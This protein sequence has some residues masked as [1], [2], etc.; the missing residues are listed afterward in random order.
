MMHGN[1]K[2]KLSVLVYFIK[3]YNFLQK[4]NKLKTQA[5]L[6][7]RSCPSTRFFSL[8][9]SQLPFAVRVHVA[10]YGWFLNSSV[11]TISFLL[12]LQAMYFRINFFDMVYIWWSIKQQ[13][14]LHARES[15][16]QF[17]ILLLARLRYG[18]QY[19]S[20]YSCDWPT[21]QKFP[22]FSSVFRQILR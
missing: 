7:G 6:R 16:E 18:S 11:A 2:L 5:N 10:I 20:G 21:A 17:I 9:K 22:L 3:V 8:K 1:M 19:E 4:I 14:S 12:I 15:L 13:H